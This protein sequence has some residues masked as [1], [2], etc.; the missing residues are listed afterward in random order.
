MRRP[1]SKPGV[2]VADDS[3]ATCSY[4]GALVTRS[5]AQAHLAASLEEAR[6]VA[7]AHDLDLA[8]IDVWFPGGK[9]GFDLCRTLADLPTRVPSVLITGDSDPEVRLRAFSSG[10]VAF[11][12]KPVSMPLIEQDLAFAMQARNAPH[13]LLGKPANGGCGRLLVVDDDEEWIKLAGTVFLAGGFEV[14]AAPDGRQGLFAASR[15]DYDVVLLDH[16]LPGHHGEELLAAFKAGRRPHPPVV[17]MWTASP[18]KG[19]E[20]HCWDRGADDYVVKDG[21]ALDALVSRVYQRAGLT[22]YGVRLYLDSRRRQAGVGDARSPALNDHEMAFLRLLGGDKGNRVPKEIVLRHVYGGEPT[23]GGQS[24]LKEMVKRL[25][26]KL[27]GE[28]ARALQTVHG[29]GYS[30]NSQL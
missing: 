10:A 2:L 12:T 11:H 4:L 1:G 25:R 24:R 30:L 28:W 16:Q 22:F 27:P 7:E 6:L 19:L 13:C 20:R 3:T 14:H 21:G 8:F 5:G 15:T 9:S 17:V 18:S 29:V 23:Q 26:E